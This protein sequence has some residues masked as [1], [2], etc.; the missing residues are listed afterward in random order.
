MHIYAHIPVHHATSHLNT[1]PSTTRQHGKEQNPLQ[2]HTPTPEPLP[3]PCSHHWQTTAIVHQAPHNMQLCQ[4]LQHTWPAPLGLP[5][6]CEARLLARPESLSSDARLLPPRAPAANDTERESGALG[7]AVAG[8]SSSLL[9]VPMLLQELWHVTRSR[10]PLEHKARSREALPALVRPVSCGGGSGGRTAD[11]STS[12][13]ATASDASCSAA[14]C[15][16]R[17]WPPLCGGENC[18]DW[19]LQC[20]AC[21]GGDGVP[22]AAST[23]SCSPSRRA[24]EKCVSTASCMHNRRMHGRRS[25]T[26]TQSAA[27]VEFYATVKVRDV[28]RMWSSR[29]HTEQACMRRRG[30]NI[31]GPTHLLRPL[32]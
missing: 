2:L 30:P 14:C 22:L 18:T 5:S 32:K 7:G 16:A 11:R 6:G 10:A 3:H 13:S 27:C 4:N 17:C 24:R 8:P 31:M 26:H 25:T 28:R 20:S 1:P 21:C 9:H 19:M 29:R 12:L 15:G 23:K